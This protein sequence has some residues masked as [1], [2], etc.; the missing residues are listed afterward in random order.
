MIR[1]LELKD[2]EETKKLVYQV[3]TL[4]YE[5]RP[6]I[7]NDGNPLPFE[8]F[9]NIIK[10]KDTL[11]IVYEENKHIVGL[12][13]TTKKSDSSIPIMKERLTYFIEDIVVDNNHRKKGIGKKLY[14]YLLD[15]AIKENINAIELNVWSFNKSAIKFY[16]SLGM[17]VKNMKLERILTKSNI[18]LKETTLNITNKV[19]NK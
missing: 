5:S 2:Y 15:K 4:H 11:K 14:D 16:E 17:S 7:Y 3:H 6:D 1:T 10:D 18:E 9:E 13:I 19:K 12:L 8:Y